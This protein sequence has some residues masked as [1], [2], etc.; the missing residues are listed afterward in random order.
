MLSADQQEFMRAAQLEIMPDVVTIHE[1]VEVSDGAGGL[2]R[3]WVERLDI[4]GRPIEYPARV[5]SPSGEEARIVADK[6][7]PKRG[8]ILTL[9]YDVEIEEQARVELNGELFQVE[10]ILNRPESIHTALRCVLG[11]V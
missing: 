1:M 10:A 2:T 6:L 4:Q 3:T 9:P 11:A 8:T 7:G 5:G